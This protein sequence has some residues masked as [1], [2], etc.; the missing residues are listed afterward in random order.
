MSQ[1]TPSS[2]PSSTQW[3][4]GRFVKTLSY[5]G[6]VPF[7]S[8][9][10]WFQ[11][12]FGSRPDPK[13]DSR[14]LAAD[15]ASRSIL[16]PSRTI[17]VVEA[18]GEQAT[19]EQLVGEEL[20]RQLA[21]QGHLARLITQLEIA[22]SAPIH[23]ADSA[24]HRSEPISIICCGNTAAEI[25]ALIALI[26]RSKNLDSGRQPIF[27][28]AD[29][30]SDVREV[31]GALDDVVMGG[32]SQSNIHIAEGV[33]N[34]SGTVST[35][36]SG[37]FASVRTR[38]LEP[39]LDLST[40]DGIEL[41]VKGD[42]KRYKFMLRTEAQWDGVAYCYSFDT[43]ADQWL[44][45]RIP[46]AE[47]V[48]VFRARTVANSPVDPSHV[49]AWQLMLSK[50]EYDGALNPHFE[51]GSFQL[52]I[53]SIQ[54][55][56]AQARFVL[57]APADTDALTAA[58]KTSGIPYTILHP[59]TIIAASTGSVQ[60]ARQPLAGEISAEAVAAIS[61]AA[62]E[63]PEACQ[64]TFFVTGSAEP[65]QAASQDWQQLFTLDSP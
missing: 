49:T 41:R 62:L 50:F 36:N 8:N 21:E 22:G 10:D 15:T 33:A 43:V 65:N 3:N 45:V 30:A 35:A 2:T 59:S 11:Q 18:A 14:L 48:P 61:I 52:Q 34:F 6:A 27:D 5:F 58:L 37:G 19:G 28:F 53:A 20:V 1:S 4:L 60:V 55:Y 31:W 47:L 24:T 56:R 7:L 54:V 16:Q 40:Y 38:N 46:F 13:V 51:P 17:L 42:G 9:L 39:P 57:I 32:V 44:T 63:S 25:Q 23:S 64:Q 12:W 29:P 26:D